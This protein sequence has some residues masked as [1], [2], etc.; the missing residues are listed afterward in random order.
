MKNIK[1]SSN[2]QCFYNI[3]GMEK[4]I[5]ISYTLFNDISELSEIDKKLFEVAK[6][7]RLQA[8]A[9]YSNFLVGCAVLL[10]NGTIAM[11][12]NQ[13]NAVYPVG[14]CAERVALNWISANF[15]TEQI[16]KLFVIGAPK[17]VE[18]EIIPAPPCGICRQAISE[19][20]DK[21]KQPIE[22]YFANLSGKVYKVNSVKTILPFTFNKEFL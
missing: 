13:E 15:P 20:E 2:L 11:G 19:Y 14:T 3:L 5:K 21:Q 16:E 17:D 8:Y 10:K 18:T 9:P 1:K 12:N 7:A 22:V 4:E 6:K